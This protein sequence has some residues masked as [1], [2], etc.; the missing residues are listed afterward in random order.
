MVDR[1]Q[2]FK[3]INAIVRLFGAKS[4]RAHVLDLERNAWTQPVGAAGAPAT[5][6]LF[7]DV[8]TP[9]FAR[10]SPCNLSNASHSSFVSF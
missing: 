9:G 1:I 8:I 7:G 5:L 2:K 4:R 10:E 6:N 3:G